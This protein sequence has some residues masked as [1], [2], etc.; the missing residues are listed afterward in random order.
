M[1][2]GG[3]GY[4]IHA[5]VP[6]AVVVFCAGF[7]IVGGQIAAN[8]LAANYYPTPIRSTGVG[9]ALGVGRIGSIVGPL[10]VGVLLSRH[11]GAELLFLGA[12]T[13]VAGACLA[14][15]AISRLAGREPTGIARMN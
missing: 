5:T 15:F 1:S 10:V 14:A 4:A 3:I 7:S 13:P 12:A 2:V 11:V 6:A 9:W 8:A